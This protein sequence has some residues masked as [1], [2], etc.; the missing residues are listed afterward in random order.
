MMSSVAIAMAIGHVRPRNADPAIDKTSTISP[1]AYATDEIAS[2][3]NT[4]N[5]MK[6]LSLW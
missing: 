4:A 2:L 5:A 6:L 3:E 1:V